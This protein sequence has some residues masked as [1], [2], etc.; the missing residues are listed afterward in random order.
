[1]QSSC[2]T[3]SESRSRT[4]ISLAS[5]DIFQSETQVAERN[6]DLIAARYQYKIALDAMRQL[7]GADLTPALRETEI[8]LEDD[9]AELPPRESILPFEQALKKAMNV[10]PE[11]LATQ[12][13]IANDNLN[14]RIARDQLNPQLDLTLQGGATGPA[15][16][17][18][19][20]SGTPVS[21]GLPGI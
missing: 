12:Q 9:P 10:R 6:R 2:A 17:A 5:L 8:V 20:A 1:M 11:L 14:A 13:S 19:T 15:Y 21:G 7:I 16:P 4:S 18:L 3:T